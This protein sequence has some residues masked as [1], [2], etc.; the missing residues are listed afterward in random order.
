MAYRFI[1]VESDD[2]VARIILN[3]PDVLNSVNLEMAREL[4]DA[5]DAAGRDERVRA[6]LLSAAGRAFCAGQDLAA[7][8]LD[9]DMDK[10]VLGDTVRAQYN[11]LI[12]GLRELEKPIV[13]AVNGVAAGAGASI[14]FACDVVIA[15]TEASFALSFCRIGLIPDSGATYTVPRLAGVGRAAAICLLGERF[16]A[17]QAR[18]WG[19][20][21]DTCPAAELEDRTLT[22]A[23][24]LAALPTR[25]LALTKQALNSS[26]SNG[27][28]E[29]LELEADLQTEAGHTADFLEGVRAF[30]EKRK[31]V[32]QGR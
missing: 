14:A 6:I 8:P 4:Q 32:F 29:Q 9:A 17:A 16:S 1:R 26:M 18:E 23:R 31:P 3:R 12:L 27:L 22:I 19:L 15:S 21:W 13:C 2:A 24:T 25:A 28:R 20:I 11:P 7:V 10:L 5:L 30:R